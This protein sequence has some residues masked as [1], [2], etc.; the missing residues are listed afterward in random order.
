MKE[1]SDVLLMHYEENDFASH[2]NTKYWLE[3]DVSFSPSTV[4]VPLFRPLVS[5]PLPHLRI[6]LSTTLTPR[7]LNLTLTPGS[8]AQFS[9]SSRASL[10][11]L[12]SPAL[13]GHPSRLTDAENAAAALR[14]QSK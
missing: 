11:H 9:S 13:F 14:E 6:A 1:L 2:P 7:N 5:S 3:A 12:T 10:S 4:R 8:H